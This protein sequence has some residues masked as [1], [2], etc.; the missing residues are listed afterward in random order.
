MAI[1]G[2]SNHKRWL[3]RLRSWDFTLGTVVLLALLI[4]VLGGAVFDISTS[5]SRKEERV[6][7]SELKGQL[8]QF[9]L[10]T[11]EPDG[12][13]LLEN[14]VDFS[15]VS[16]P[17]RIVTLRQS[18]F[19]YVLQTGNAKAFNTGD[20]TFEAPRA[21]QVE[22]PGSRRE[23]ALAGNLRACFAV[24]PGDQAGRYVYFSLRYPSN[25]IE[26]H[27]AGRQL[28]KVNRVVLFFNG[29]RESRLTLVYQV[30]PLARSRYPSQLAR[31]EQ[32]HEISGF[33]TSEG[34]FSSRLVSGQAYESQVEENGSAPRNFVTVVGRLDASFLHPASMEDPWP[35]AE[36]KRIAIGVKIYDKAESDSETSILFDVPPGKEGTPLASLTQAYLAAVPSRA[37]LQVTSPGTGGKRRVIWRS[38]EAAIT[39]SSTRL[40]GWWQNIADSWSELIISKGVLQ[41]APV[42]A[43]ETVRIN[44]FGNASAFLTA[45]PF[46]LPDLATRAFTWISA[47]VAL[48]AIL[49]FYWGHNVLKL[50]RLR[51]V[52]YAM[53]VRPSGGGD[54]KQFSARS[55]NGTLARVFYLLLTRSRS[56]DANLVKRQRKQE[57]LR[58]EKLRLAEAHV[59][60]RKAIL[61]AIGHEIRAPLQSLVNTT[62]GQEA[63]QQKLARIRRAVEALHAATSVEDGLRSGDVATSPHNLAD[64]LQR[65]AYNLDEDGRGVKF[66][67]PAH[68]VLVQMDSMQLEQILD[69]LLENAERFRVPGSKIELR[70]TEYSSL[71]ELAVFNYGEPIPDADIERIFD[72]GVTD[73][74]APSNSGLGLFAS[75]I[76]A[77]AMDATLNARNEVDGVSLVLQFPRPVPV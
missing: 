30:P 65:F 75:R 77:L 51:A 62:K 28:T 23:G 70:L 1:A 63:V 15:A 10:R 61:D 36:L 72:L 6:Q 64:W 67:G 3:Q 54:L 42:Q 5:A 59:Q 31:F 39:Q 43:S 76:Y 48:I 71:I 37:S 66:V 11:R 38:D 4:A 50:R 45:T 35:S 25:K 18:F 13:S 17:L 9:L 24:V 73:S 46:T 69:N 8:A 41:S 49:A 19:S 44:G 55:E 29:H 26:R 12:S 27:R 21:C 57:F 60:N 47:A 56:R 40:D 2:K 58:A 22:Y 14:P 33:A 74:D 32:V 52:A 16:R 20:I 34:G 53:T 68:E 7:A